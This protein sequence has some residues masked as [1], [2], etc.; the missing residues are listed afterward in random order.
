[1]PFNLDEKYVLEAEEQLKAKLPSEYKNA[2]VS[3][4]GGDIDINDEIWEQYPIF[5]KSDRKRL[6]RTCNHIIT[7]TDSC[8]DFGNFGENLLAI[9]SNGCGDQLVFVKEGK[10]YLPAVHIWS[11]ETGKLTQVSNSFNA[12]MCI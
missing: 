1:M 8:K 11:H 7:E 9:A 12:V 4:N 5:D 10:E 2:M 6:S 3:N